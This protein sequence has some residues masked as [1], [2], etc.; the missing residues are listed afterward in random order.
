DQSHCIYSK[1]VIHLL[2]IPTWNM[3]VYFSGLVDVLLLDSTGEAVAVSRL[4]SHSAADSQ[5]SSGPL[6]KDLNTSSTADCF[7]MVPGISSSYVKTN[8]YMLY[9]ILLKYKC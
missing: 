2:I 6:S 4:H 7:L 3:D 5:R 9:I 8:T 1:H